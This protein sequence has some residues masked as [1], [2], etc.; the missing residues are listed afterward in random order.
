M[1]KLY[2]CETNNILAKL[3]DL[4]PLDP[5]SDDCCGRDD[6]F[7]CALGFEP[8]CLTLPRVLAECGYKASRARYFEYTTNAV[9]NE[10]N[11]QPL[12][13][14]LRRISCSVEAIRCDESD[15][16][17]RFTRVV[18]D[19]SVDRLGQ[20]AR[21]TFDISVAANRLSMTCMRLLLD[22]DVSL[23][24]LYTE[25]AVYH[26]TEEEYRKEPEK[27]ITADAPGLEVGVGDLSLSKELPGH[28]LDA[29]P[30]S[31][32]IFPNL[33]AARSKAVIS[34]IDPSLLTSPG[35]SVVWML[36]ESKRSDL[37]WR[38]EEMANINRISST[39]PRYN[40]KVVEYRDTLRALEAAYSQ[41]WEQTNVSLAQF[42][43]KLQC[44]GTSLFCYIHPDVRV[45]FATPQKYNAAHYSD[46][47][48]V[49]WKVDFGPI[50][51]LRELLDGIGKIHIED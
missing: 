40:V 14:A 24:V 25:A 6:L 19:L 7:V 41:I 32:I 28:H 5:R 33:K 38:L 47:A 16:S 3:P 39:T 26:P 29:L 13:E 30:N 23:R 49:L 37:A 51:K 10:P 35:K 20:S 34:K 18:E 22:H 11:R 46:G 27:W 21:I 12:E 15:F 50:P 2:V 1:P 31:I 43:S 36:G 44:L 42:G 48:S 17:S 8:R 45:W 4:V 9:D